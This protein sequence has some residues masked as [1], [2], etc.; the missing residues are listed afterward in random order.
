MKYSVWELSPERERVASLQLSRSGGNTAALIVGWREERKSITGV[1]R[2][3]LKLSGRLPSKIKGG[4]GGF[5]GGK[6]ESDR[7]RGIGLRRANRKSVGERFVG[8]G[9][10]SSMSCPKWFQD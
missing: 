4:G 8:R 6:D 9:M 10:R 5:R 2:G 7:G 3:K 1:I